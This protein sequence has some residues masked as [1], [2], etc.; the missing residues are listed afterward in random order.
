V[1]EEKLWKTSVRMGSRWV[2]SQ[3]LPIAKPPLTEMQLL[4][5]MLRMKHINWLLLAV[6]SLGH[7]WNAQ[8]FV[9]FRSL[10]HHSGE[11]LGTLWQ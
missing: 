10:P 3:D 4:G 1:I 8:N 2:R 7:L 6:S 9:L 5:K 11:R